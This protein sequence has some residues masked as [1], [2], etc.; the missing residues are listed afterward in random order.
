MTKFLLAISTLSLGAQHASAATILSFSQKSGRSEA[1][2]VRVTAVPPSR[3]KVEYLTRNQPQ[4]TVIWDIS[5]KVT[6][7]LDHATR[8][9]TETRPKDLQ[10]ALDEV[11]D[12]KRRAT[13]AVRLKGGAIRRILGEE[14][15][16]EEMRAGTKPIWRACY[17]PASSFGLDKQAIALLAHAGFA[18]S[19]GGANLLGWKRT[20]SSGAA[21][22][23][24]ELVSHDAKAPDP[25]PGFFSVP[26]G[27]RKSSQR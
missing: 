21:D 1:K 24:L 27:F 8:T 10:K 11:K 12:P 9:F 3:I 15:I 19:D 23:E 5:T 2:I 16:P 17:L 20:L 4:T 14:C 22:F 7:T 18:R 26:P 25:D 6:R 13:P